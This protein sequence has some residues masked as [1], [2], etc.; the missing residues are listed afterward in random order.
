MNDANVE[1]RS[2]FYLIV[3]CCGLYIFLFVVLI[4]VGEFYF[5][6]FTNRVLFYGKY[7]YRPETDGDLFILFYIK[8]QMT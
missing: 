1:I 3:G 4:Y 7:T 6:Y 2:G 5:F 8:Y